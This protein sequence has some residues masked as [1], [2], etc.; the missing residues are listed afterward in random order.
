MAEIA[1]RVMIV[2]YKILII[3]AFLVTYNEKLLTEVFS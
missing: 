3:S 2:I 1:L